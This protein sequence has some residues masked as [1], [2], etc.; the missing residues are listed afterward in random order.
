MSEYPVGLRTE[1]GVL[2]EVLAPATRRLYWQGLV[3]V[4]VEVIDIATSADVPA[5]VLA[6]LVQT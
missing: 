2:V 5:S 1:N 3:D 4:K 6:R